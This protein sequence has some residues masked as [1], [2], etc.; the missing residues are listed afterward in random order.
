VI[1]AYFLPTAVGG[2]AARLSLLFAVP[3]VVAYVDW[4]RWLYATV[5]IACVVIQTPVTLGTLT[6]AGSA[7]TRASYF[8]PVLDEIRSLGP[9]TGRVEIPELTGHWEAVYAARSVP[10][11][12]GWLRQVDTELN[13]A[14]FYQHRPTP[15][16]YR[17]FLQRSAVSYVAVPDARATYYGRR[18]TALIATHLPYLTEIWHD[19]HWHLYAVSNP[20]PIAQSPATLVSYGGAS[21]TIDAPA[22]TS[23]HLNLRW[24]SFLSLTGED[25]AGCLEPTRDSGTG[26]IGG[27]DGV[28][29][30]TDTG[31]RYIVSSSLTGGRH[32]GSP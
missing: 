5:V 8:Q 29:L 12:R 15:T 4:R 17:T 32:C 26:S 16:T 23:V 22:H 11:A 2:N 24:F 14:T 19:A 28:T 20:V 27:S 3:I 18:E 25:R 13:D 6:G 1:A 30:V 7:A 9:L 21:I 31:G 10:L